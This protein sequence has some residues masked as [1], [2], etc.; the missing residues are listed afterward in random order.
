[1]RLDDHL[2][3]FVMGYESVV[4]IA[5]VGVSFQDHLWR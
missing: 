1:M 5:E 4:C 3:E 2:D